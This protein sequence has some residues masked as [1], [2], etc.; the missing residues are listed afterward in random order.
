VFFFHDEQVVEAAEEIVS[1]DGGGV[2]VAA[3]EGAVV[4]DDGDDVDGLEVLAEEGEELEADRHEGF[5]LF[6]GVG[7]VEGHVAAVLEHAIDF[8]DDFGHGGVVGVFAGAV[9]AGVQ[10]SDAAGVVGIIDMGG[11]G[12]IDEDEVDG[13]FFQG[14]VAGVGRLD[15]GAQLVAGEVEAEGLAL[16]F[17]GDVDG[18]AGAAH[19]V[20]DGVTLAGVAGEKLPDDP[21]GGG[22]DVVFIAVGFAAVVLGGILPERCGKKMKRGFVHFR[23]SLV[24]AKECDETRLFKMAITAGSF[25]EPSCFKDEK[26]DAISQGPIFVSTTF[27]KLDRAALERLI[28]MHDFRTAVLQCGED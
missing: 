26:G 25:R 21:G 27:K 11:V 12:G 17:V 8:G 28:D 18:G 19:G 23:L 9:G 6:E 7:D 13:F 2:P 24:L 15:V 5:A 10:F 20:E 14:Q 22:A 1:F 3:L 4:A 16:E